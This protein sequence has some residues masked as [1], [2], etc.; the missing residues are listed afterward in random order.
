MPIRN[1]HK[2]GDSLM[3]D[4]E[5]G[6]VHYRS[7]MVQIWDGTWRHHKSFETRHPQE[8]VKARRDPRALR[9]VRPEPLVATPLTTVRG[10]IGLTDIETG[11]G[12]AS[13]LFEAGIGQ[14]VIE[15]G[16]DAVVFKVR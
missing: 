5:S 16:S 10:Q 1:T 2:V 11:Q 7:E 9:H 8:F 4:D 6:L 15:E 14:M 13:H 12:P 3:M